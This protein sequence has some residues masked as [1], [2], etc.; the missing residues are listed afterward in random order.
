MLPRAMVETLGYTQY[1]YTCR[2][3]SLEVHSSLA[4][5]GEKRHSSD[6]KL[7][8]SSRV[9]FPFLEQNQN[10]IFVTR[11]SL[12]MCLGFLA[13]ILRHLADAGV[14]V[15]VASGFY[16][17]HLFVQDGE[18]EL[19]M[20]LLKE[21]SQSVTE[22]SEEEEEEEG[23]VRKEKKLK[24]CEKSQDLDSKK[25]SS[26]SEKETEEMSN[27]HDVVVVC[28]DSDYDHDD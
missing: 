6:T 18:E 2:M 26:D 3:V 5:V 12:T 27:N 22:S 16:H 10:S 8:S 25:E 7:K 1:E 17:D 15:N 23:G 20:E 19:V 28:S 9:I 14:S 4:A 11:M 13:V 24:A 21:L